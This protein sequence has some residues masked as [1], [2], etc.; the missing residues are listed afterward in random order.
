MLMATP[1]QI[2]QPVKREVTEPG[3]SLVLRIAF[4]FC[5][6]YFGLFCVATQIIESL[7][8]IRDVDI[9][10]LSTLWPLRQLTFWVAA[11]LF[12]ARLPLA[13]TG[14]SGDKTFDW[15]LIFC[16][17][18][19]ATLATGIW[20]VLDRRR[21]NYVTL[22]KWFRLAIR[23]ALAGQM[24]VYG[25]DKFIPLQMPFPFLTRLLE[26]FHD[27][28]PMG[29]LWA[30]IGSSPAY[31]T[32]A[33][34]AEL[35]GGILL[36]FPRTTT[37]GALIC[38]ADMTQV[39]ML[40]MTY[41]VPVKILSFHL[42]LMSLLLLAPELRRLADF[43]FGNR[44]VGPSMQPQLFEAR[45]ANRIAIIAQIV[46]GIWLLG[47]NGYG[48]WSDWP[49]YGGGSPKP[50]L[51]GIWNVDE[52][53]LDGR[54]RAPL[55]TDYDR[56][57]RLVFDVRNVAAFQRMDDSFARYTAAVDTSHG[58]ITLTKGS[59]KNWKAGFTFQRPAADQ[60][61]VDG[62]MDGRAVHMQLRLVDRSKFMLVSRGF[63][64]VQENPFNR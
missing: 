32:F 6:V 50:A 59:D 3:W 14:G 46:F 19:F 52:L 64:W 13:Y 2:T 29:V 35:L 55:L 20:S 53:S 41:D 47:M 61:I 51:Y 18:I 44:A 37:L 49:T 60:L 30:S 63:H 26:P 4:R 58:K 8:P 28:S 34:S 11:R 21:K 42:A 48:A 1:V 5:F 40:N 62:N 12:Q 39:F 10:N 23:F 38:L 15:V 25:M 33:G 36:V 24:I 22:F 56:W 17:L 45:R 57:R 54:L 16:L 31:E 43:F 7:L 9:P 27:F